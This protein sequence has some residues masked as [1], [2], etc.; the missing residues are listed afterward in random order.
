MKL[1][2][3]ISLVTIVLLGITTFYSNCTPQHMVG[4]PLSSINTAEILQSLQNQSTTILSQR[5]ASCHN[6]NSTNSSL[7]DILDTQYLITA[8]YIDP[9]SPQTS[10]LYM[11]VVD[12]IMPQGGPELSVE[13]IAVLRDWIAALGGNFDTFIGAVDGPTTG[14]TNVIGT[15]LQVNA[16]LQQ[17]CVA[18]HNGQRRPNLNLPYA[19]LIA[20]TTAAGLPLI[21]PGEQ[22]NSRLYLSVANNSM[23]QGSPLTNTQKEIIRTWVAAGARND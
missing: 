23:P 19:Q 9:G 4:A 21:S 3:K 1:A 11:N 20:E 8:G 16:I 12:K 7:K 15:F 5:C 14:N 10:L 13:D 17:R 18:C 22:S 6:D 2:F